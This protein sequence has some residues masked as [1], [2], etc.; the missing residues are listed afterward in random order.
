MDSIHYRWHL[1]LTSL[2]FPREHFVSQSTQLRGFSRRS[3]SLIQSVYESL[4]IK[5]LQFL[6]HFIRTR[7]NYGTVG[8]PEWKQCE[9]TCFHKPLESNL[10]RLQ[11]AHT[12]NQAFLTIALFKA[13]DFVLVSC[14]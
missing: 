13:I 12:A 2:Q 14:H 1:K 6:A 10:V 4:V 5:I 8:S 11:S 3:E 9:W 7:P